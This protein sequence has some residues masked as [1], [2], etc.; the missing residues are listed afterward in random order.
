[1]IFWGGTTTPPLSAECQNSEKTVL[2]SVISRV[3]DLSNLSDFSATFRRI[4]GYLARNTIK[5]YIFI[6]YLIVLYTSAIIYLS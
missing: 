5:S 4:V 1:M 2:N 3:C 6:E